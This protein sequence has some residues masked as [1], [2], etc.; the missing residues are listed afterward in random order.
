[1][2]P[3][4]NSAQRPVAPFFGQFRFNTDTALLEFFNG[5]SFITLAAGGNITYTVDQFTGDGSTT[6]FTMSEQESASTQILVFVG[7][8]YQDPFS[9]YTVNGG[10]DITFTSPPPQGEP[11]SVIHSDN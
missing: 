1:M 11:I 5:N 2:I 3:A 4:G 9:A 8:I 7:S 10:F 6:V